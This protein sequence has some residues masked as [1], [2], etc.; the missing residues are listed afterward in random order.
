MQAVAA[1]FNVYPTLHVMQEVP[2]AH[3][4]Q[5]EKQRLQAVPVE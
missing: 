4:M 5:L 3:S 1:A 2:V